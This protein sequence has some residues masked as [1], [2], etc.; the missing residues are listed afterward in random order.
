MNLYEGDGMV[1]VTNF[2]NVCDDC[3]GLMILA[4]TPTCNSNA[5][6]TIPN[7]EV[8]TGW[9][10]GQCQHYSDTEGDYCG[11][12]LR[13]EVL[14]KQRAYVAAFMLGGWPAVR[15]MGVLCRGSEL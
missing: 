8:A 1:S 13:P 2:V 9:S 4:T 5:L 11:G 12:M 6:W 3:H 14:S 10:S 7:D 15:A